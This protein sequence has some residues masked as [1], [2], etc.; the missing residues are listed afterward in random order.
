[1]DA[2]VPS[3]FAGFWKNGA[4]VPRQ[5][6]HPAITAGAILAA[7]RGVRQEAWEKSRGGFPP[8]LG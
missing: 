4:F 5:I 8:R 3:V 7:I 2:I 1:M 6:P